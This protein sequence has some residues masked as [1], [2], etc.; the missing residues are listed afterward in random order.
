[1]CAIVNVRVFAFLQ[2]L[3]TNKYSIFIYTHTEIFFSH[4]HHYCVAHFK[5]L[6][7]FLYFKF[8]L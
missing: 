7:E 3:I 5:K 8:P 1:M 4:R 2:I 6:F